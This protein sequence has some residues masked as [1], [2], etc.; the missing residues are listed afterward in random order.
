MWKW[1]FWGR[2][3]IEPCIFFSHKSDDE[4]LCETTSWFHFV[5]M[6]KV[7]ALAQHIC[8]KMSA[9]ITV[10][11][12]LSNGWKQFIKIAQSC[13]DTQTFSKMKL[14]FPSV[15]F[16]RRNTFSWAEVIL[17]LNGFK[18]MYVHLLRIGQIM[19][20]KVLK[21]RF[22]FFVCVGSARNVYQVLNKFLKLFL[23]YFIIFVYFYSSMLIMVLT[24]SL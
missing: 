24:I 15:I 9:S 23:F 2:I 3:G 20:L 1:G 12:L 13:L 19:H 5:F 14:L 10:Y 11:F 17:L 18:D 22:C 8:S 16:V 21:W 4:S 6:H 7:Q